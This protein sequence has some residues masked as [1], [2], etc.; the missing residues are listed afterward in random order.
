M[1]KSQVEFSKQC[2]LDELHN[3]MLNLLE[4]IDRVCE[5][6]NIKYFLVDGT[7]LG[8]VRHKGFIP[9]DD[10]VDIAMP[11]LDY[12]RFKNIASEKLGND[13]FVQTI[14]TDSNYHQFYI[15]LKVRDNHSTL[16]EN[17]GNK[18]HEGVYVDVFPF[19][20]LTEKKE[21]QLKK[22][23]IAYLFGVMRGPV[24]FATFPSIHCLARLSLQMI[25]H[26]IPRK[27]M[28]N[29]IEAA[30]EEN[31]N[32][33]DGDEMTYG[34]ELPWR[35]VFKTKDIFPLCRVQF[36]NLELNV[37]N[38]SDAILS[39][40]FGDYMKLPPAEKRLTHAKFYSNERLF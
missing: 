16:I 38:N 7:L 30:V 20:Y 12:E 1:K 8:A 6:E 5:E 36:E 31:I 26:L 33:T 37:P 2:S 11:R 40:I 25:G 17:Y 15:P 34:Y 3:I 27:I 35:Q 21:K 18:F 10:D 22:K 29:Y 19:D 28:I 4:K 39:I 9:W 14:N 24:Q 32:E 23:R 13:F